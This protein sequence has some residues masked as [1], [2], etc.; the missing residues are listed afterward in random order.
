MSR[1]KLV[2]ALLPTVLPWMTT[3]PLR[4]LLNWGLRRSLRA[5]RLA[6]TRSPADFGLA[7]ATVRIPTANG[8]TL[9]AWHLP[10]L[11][12]VA[13]PSPALV[14]VHGWGSNADLMLPLAPAL[15]AA[16]LA[17]LFIDTRCHGASDDEPFTSLPRFAEDTVHAVDWLAAQPDIDPSRIALLGHS[18]GAGAVLLAATWRPQIAAVVSLAAFAHPA[19]MMQRWMAEQN[20]PD[21]V[22]GPYILQYVQR[23]I[24]YR[25]DAIAPLTNLPQLRCP[26]LLMHGEHDTTVPVEDAHRLLAAA[27]RDSVQ[28]HIGPGGHDSMDAFLEQMPL[29]IG[30]LNQVNSAPSDLANR[31]ATD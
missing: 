11:P 1:S 2:S 3:P 24:G 31:I 14:I 6:H 7:S 19:D 26:V 5:S 28:L 12:T 9:H 20:L 29:V 27:A 30:F 17:L 16:G 4:P 23:T 18:V 25:F 13:R 21:A 15:H 8:K 10:A 22:I